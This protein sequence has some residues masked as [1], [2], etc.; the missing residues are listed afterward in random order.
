MGKIVQIGNSK[1]LSEAIIEILSNPEK[2]ENKNDDIQSIYDPDQIAERYEELFTTM[3][4]E[5]NKSK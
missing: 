2:Y 4:K 3:I 1:A 5:I